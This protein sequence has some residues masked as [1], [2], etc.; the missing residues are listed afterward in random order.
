MIKI[1]KGLDLPIEGNPM[2]K[3]GDS[4]SVSKVGVTGVDYVGL[5]PTMRVQEGDVVKKGQILF[6]H[7]NNE[8]FHVTAPAAGNIVAINR[9]ARRLLESIEIKPSGHD[10]IIFDCIAD[11]QLTPENKA[12]IQETLS[13]S[14]LWTSF[15]TRP[16]SKVP[17]KEQEPGAIFVTAMDSR[18]FA[19][20]S[21]LVI[22][23]HLQDF[24]RGVN[25]VSAFTKGA[26]YVCQDPNSHLELEPELKQ[27]NENVVF[28]TFDGPHPA[29]L[30]GTHIYHLHPVNVERMVWS[31]D[32]QDVIAIGK[33]LSTGKLWTERTVSIA[34]PV[35]KEPML[36]QVPVGACLEELTSGKIEEDIEARVISGCV[37]TGR[38]SQGKLTFLGRYHNQISILKEGRQR[39]LLGWHMPGFDKFSVKN[40]FT[41]RLLNGRKFAF[42]TNCAGSKR[43]MV[44]IGSYETVFPFDTETTF[45]LRSLLT[46]D[47]DLAVAL[48]VLEFDEDDLGLCS[49]VCP[50][51][52]EYG[53]LLRKLLE[54]I[55]KEG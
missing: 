30:V 32:Y 2:Q 54:T 55:E 31:I 42:T 21:A 45:F 34:G 40:T 52:S 28:K 50:G 20:Y 7:K 27:L 49:F 37:F 47:M 33:L 35:V 1:K 10:E 46:Q 8:L 6:S 9:G 4:P 14:G 51:K 18:P 38:Q 19:P 23:R 53:P 29:G 12:K 13:Q 36:Y 3:W 39:D 15:R 22:R 5:K 16:F 25:A 11:S 26:V 24:Q 43:A 17:T 48:G 44:P 41:S